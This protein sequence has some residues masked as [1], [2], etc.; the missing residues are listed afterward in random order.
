MIVLNQ[1][2]YT[3]DKHDFYFDLTIA[4]NEH[5]A[6][7]GENGAGKS[8]LLN[9]IMGF[10]FPISGKIIIDQK[11]YT[12]LTADKRPVSM[13]FQEH[14]LFPHLTVKQNIQL[15]FSPSLKLTPIQKQL[16]DQFVTQMNIDSFL[17]RLPH[18]L[19]GGQKQRVA[20]TR[21][22][23]QSR[24]ILLLDEPFSALDEKTR[25]EMYLLLEQIQQQQ[26]LTI[27]HVSHQHAELLHVASRQLF[28]D[29]GRIIKDQ[30]L[31]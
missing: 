12:H 3:I 27:L 21:C 11:E 17:N 30:K 18:T 13:L 9:L 16:F 2:N 25:Q 14:N 23:S 4:A 26:Q 15:G 29:N 10:I 8:T 19:S 31:T 5:V 1:L 28:L 24:P 20:L 7:L 22:L 6:I